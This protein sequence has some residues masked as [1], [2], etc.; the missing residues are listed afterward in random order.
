M[1]DPIAAATATTA[2]PNP[3]PATPSADATPPAAA[4]AAPTDWTTGF[5]DELKGY[6]Q[7]KGFKDPTAVLDSYRNL[8]KLIGVPHEQI[9]KLP[10][11]DDAEGWGKVYDRLGRPTSPDEYKLDGANETFA[12]WAKGTFHELGFTKAQA[13]KFATKINEY[14]QGNVK[15]AEEAFQ[16]KLADQEKALKKEWGAAFDQNIA[17]AKRTASTLGMS[18]EVVDSLEKAMGF[19]GVMKFVH[20]LGAKLGEDS[21]H[22]GSRNGGG[23]FGVLTPEQA[24]SRIAALGSDPA[25]VARYQ[26]GDASA[27]A[28]MDNLHKWGYPEN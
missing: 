7:N 28:E 1:S 23:G 24:R 5:N 16:T 27:R 17:A 3:A 26:S 10:K 25:F 8:E 6:V 20:G 12:K 15:A 18:P 11:E 21:F 13:E 19:D 4:P 22:A 9:L 2:T 14:A